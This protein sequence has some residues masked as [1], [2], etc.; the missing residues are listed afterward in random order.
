[1]TSRLRALWDARVLPGL[2]ERACRSHA[3]LEE[4]QRWVPQASGAV[5]EIG[6]GSGLNLGFYDPARVTTLVGIDPSA[7][8]L[9]RAQVRSAAAPVPPEL[10]EAAAED[11]PFD[12]HRFDTAL[13]SYTLCSVATPARALAEVRRVLRPGG[14]LILIEH[15]RAPE[16]RTYA[17]QRRLTPLWRTISGNCHLDRDPRQ[18]VI[19]AGFELDGLEAGHAPDGPRWLSYTYQG[20]AIAP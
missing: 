13:I 5:V 16:P 20:T 17:W 8:L 18:L 14:R 6:I 7:P 12:A 15:G 11:L 19:D 3:I 4:R 1:M 2:V 10:I 9:A